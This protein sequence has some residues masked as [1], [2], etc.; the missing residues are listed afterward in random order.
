MK[1]EG[2]EIT[3]P[4]KVIFPAKKITKGDMAEYYA[5]VADIMLP[6]LKN[7]PLTL[8]RFPAGIKNKGF[9]QKNAS[10]HF[11]RYIKLIEI[12]TEDGVNTQI[13]CNNKKT[14]IYLVNQNTVAFHI[15]LSRKDK[16]RQP[17]KV[18]F[19]LDPPADSFEKVKEAAKTLRNYL[20]KKNIDPN[21]MTTGQN[22]LHIYYDIRRGKD[23]DEVKTQVKSMADELVELRPDL[24]TTK[25]RKDQRDGKIFVD[26]L[27][28]AYAQTGIC[29][30]SLRS[31][32]EAGIATPIEWEEL[33]KLESASY[34][35][36]ENILDRIKNNTNNQKN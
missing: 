28:N 36:F 10:D 31:N 17:D 9:Y 11:P 34:F 1:I 35:N 14:L 16:I 4:E 8:K 22:G 24:L 26:Y 7:R 5:E 20:Q 3:H 25:I 33:E 15:W 32:E 18:I 29:P 2:V 13:L 19:D 6:Y 12:E 21:L 23:F 30:Y 27:R